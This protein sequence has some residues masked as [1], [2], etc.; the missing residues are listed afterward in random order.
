MNTLLRLTA[1]AHPDIN[2][3]QPYPVYVDPERIFLVERSKTRQQRWGW[4]DE[5]SE[6]TCR[7]WDEVQRCAGDM[8]ASTPQDFMPDSEEQANRIGK[9]IHN[10]ATRRD[11][12]ASITT[13]Y[14]IMNQLSQKPR[15]YPTTEATCISFAVA[16]AHYSMLPSVFVR[17]TPE[18]IAQLIAQHTAKKIP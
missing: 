17:E 15:Y 2:H 12:A 14:G 7:F 5:Q 4:E 10:W 1:I 11:I 3:G 16:N 8:S 13:A 18:Q 9:D 6:L